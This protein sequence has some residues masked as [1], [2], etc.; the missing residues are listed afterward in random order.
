[1][2]SQ[3]FKTEL[4]KKSDGLKL[5]AKIKNH[6]QNKEEEKKKQ[7][8]K[9]SYKRQQNNLDLTL[10]KLENYNPKQKIEKQL[11]QPQHVMFMVKQRENFKRQNKATTLI[12]G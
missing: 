4:L 6:N 5:V 11:R 12:S 8:I 7:Q 10:W 2:N 1:M 9:K 3:T